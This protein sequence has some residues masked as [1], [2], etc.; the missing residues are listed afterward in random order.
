MSHRLWFHRCVTRRRTRPAAT[1]APPSALVD[2]AHALSNA[3]ALLVSQ[4]E[5]DL[6]RELGS[7]ERSVDYSAFGRLFQ[8]HF[9]RVVQAR[10]ARNAE[11]FELLVASTSNGVGIR[12][13][14]AATIFDRLRQPP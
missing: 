13:V 2:D 1:E 8:Q 12:E 14:L 4:L 11:L 7:L 6:V 5:E 9:D 10:R 3:D